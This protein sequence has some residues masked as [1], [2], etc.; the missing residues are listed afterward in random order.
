MKDE[1]KT[2]AELIKESKTLRKERE[3]SAL[4][5][6]TKHKQLEGKYQ[7]FTKDILDSSAV[8]MFILS[9]IHI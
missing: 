4:N 5:D 3:K 7:L 8:G 1:N 9:L 6:T 2:K